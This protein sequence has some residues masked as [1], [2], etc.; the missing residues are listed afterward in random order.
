M[1]FDTGIYRSVFAGFALCKFFLSFKILSSFS[2]GVSL[3]PLC[4][5]LNCFSI[6]GNLV[7]DCFAYDFPVL[8]NCAF[9]LIIGN[10]INTAQV[11]TL[12]L[13]SLKR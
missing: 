1:F 8:L 6:Y 9:N 2:I 11:I 3:D 7:I 4:T 13:T 5:F 12:T 10:I